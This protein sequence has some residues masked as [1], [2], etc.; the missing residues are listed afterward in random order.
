MEAPWFIIAILLS[1]K[2]DGN[3]KIKYWQMAIPAEIWML[4]PLLNSVGSI[5]YFT[6]FRI[7]NRWKRIALRSLEVEYDLPT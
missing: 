2:L 5:V 1:L 4:Y 6:K 3:Q 7:W